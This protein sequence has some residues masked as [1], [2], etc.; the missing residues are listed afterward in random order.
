MSELRDAIRRC[1]Q[2]RDERPV[3][4]RLRSARTDSPVILR[5]SPLQGA[6]GRP[7]ALVTSTELVWPRALKTVAQDAFGLTAAE[8]EIV[9]V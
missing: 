2:G 8:V 9:R 4:L 1:A 7:M 5:V 3:L 6:R